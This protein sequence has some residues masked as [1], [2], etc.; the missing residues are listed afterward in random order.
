M[1]T[2]IKVYSLML[3]VL[4]S[5]AAF[6]GMDCTD[7]VHAQMAACKSKAMDHSKMDHSK[8]DHSKMNHS[9]MKMKMP[10][11]KMDHSKMDHSKM[12]HSKMN[13][14]KM[15]KPAAK[16]DHSKMN[17]SKMKMPAAKMDHS[18][19][20]HSKMDHSK[21]NHSKM[22]KP[23][24]KMDHSK[25]D[26]SKMDHSKMNHSKM[27][28]PS[29]PVSDGSLATDVPYL[30]KKPKMED[31]PLLTKFKLELLEVHDTDDESPVTWEAE[32]WVGKDINKLWFKTE[33]ERV[34]GETEE[35][36]LQA[37]YSR[38]ID[39]YWD[40]Q[41]GLRRDFKPESRNWAVAGFKGLAPYHFETDAAVFIGESGRSAFRLQSEY[42]LMLTQKLVLSPEI[43]LNLHGKSDPELGIGSGLSDGSLGLRLRY[44]VTRQFAPYIGVEYS[45]KFGKTADFARDENEDVSD[46]QLLFGISAWF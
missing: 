39:P 43:E 38:A 3:S 32:A 37:L 16:M 14:S 21:M 10:A 28:K 40:F 2:N 29:I 13:H 1:K 11:A 31:D 34:N 23:A 27:N 44:E 8:M 15:K 42:E 5:P 18:K 9:K 46:T 17:H 22:K 25:M 20:D 33:G 24:A 12:D 35:F 6:A 36:E 4:A 41:V 45:S 26:H 7:P 30:Y 19:M